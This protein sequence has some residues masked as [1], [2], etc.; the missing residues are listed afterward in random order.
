[1]N[2]SA[3]FI[4]VFLLPASIL[5]VLFFL[6]PIAQTMYTSLFDWSGI[7]KDMT[8]IG[9]K[10]YS[11]LLHDALFIKNMTNTLIIWIFGGVMIFGLAFMFT[12]MLNSGMR[13]QRFL[14]GI[15]FLP[16]VIATVALTT[17]W[18]YIY[19]PRFGL[20]NSFLKL[21][22]LKKLGRTPWTAPDTIFWAMLIALIWIHVGFYLVLL[23]AGTDKIPFEFYE[24]ARIDGANQFQ[25][26][27][28]I[29]IPL[30]WDVIT[31]A[32]IYWSIAALKIFE[33]PF[34]FSGTHVV[35]PETYT[36]AVYLYIMGFRN[37]R[38]GY[39]SAI[40]VFMLLSVIAI[41]VILRRVMRREVIQY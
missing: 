20:L 23:M 14:R 2:V 35:A 5:Y 9:L 27:A 29:T 7:G 19:N 4:A 34:A 28:L 26:F 1:M 12:A 16:N 31:I 13:G 32:I 33:F 37:S 22:G 36:A 15:I 25:V 21:I 30:L 17:L 8:F 40:G 24:A 3:R 39:G 41:V 38:L 6:F 10:N 18:R 11:E